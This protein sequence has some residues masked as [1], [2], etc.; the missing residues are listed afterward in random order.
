M[1]GSRGMG[2][3]PPLLM[4]MTLLIRQEVGALKILE[5]SV[6]PYLRR[7]A[8]ARLECRYD[9]ESDKLHSVTWY[10][11]NVHIFSFSQ[12]S[13]KQVYSIDGV[14][15]DARN[16]NDQVLVLQNVSLNSTGYYTCEVNTNSKPFKLAKTESYMEVIEPPQ[17]DPT[18]TGEET[19]YAT[20]DILALNCTS[21]LS[22]PAAQLQ[23]FIND[24]KV[25]PDSEVLHVTSH[26]LHRTRSSLRLE[27]NP[28]HLAAGKIEIK[29]VSTVRTSALV[30]KLYRDVRS[31]KIY[32]QG[33]ASLS[34]PSTSLL[35]ATLLLLVSLQQH[36]K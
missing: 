26:G 8:T 33:Q 5:L 16:S 25:D 10:K 18:I 17:K 23:W 20:G 3:V 11:D 35:L 24:V 7:G 13:K 14:K 1:R 21:D 30:T 22:Y 6:P 29:C 28:L 27:L 9:M 31:T 32:V 12:S 34:A 2:L 15:I 19:I 4:L 36:W